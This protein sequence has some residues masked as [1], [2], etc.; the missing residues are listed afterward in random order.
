MLEVERS[1]SSFELPSFSEASEFLVVAVVSAA[2]SVEGTAAKG[3]ADKSLPVSS[4]FAVV[5]T[6]SSVVSFFFILV[7]ASA[8][9][10]AYISNIAEE[11]PPEGGADD[12]D[13]DGDAFVDDAVPFIGWSAPLALLSGFKGR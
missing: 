2:A 6:S 9:D 10:F 12:D 3:E 1:S 13:K 4:S 8:A 11:R 5:V 7:I